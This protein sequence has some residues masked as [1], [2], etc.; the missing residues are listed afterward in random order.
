MD[1]LAEE[2]DR[3]V[4]SL[5][6][7]AHRRYFKL[8]FYQHRDFDVKGLSTQGTYNLELEHVFV[9]LTIEPKP[10]HA[11]STDPIRH[12]P[13][14]LSGRRQIWDYLLSKELQD[15]LV[16]IGAPGS[17]KTTL[18]KKIVLHIISRRR[19]RLRKTIPVLLSLRDYADKIQQNPAYSLAEAV[20]DSLSRMGGSTPP[21]GWLE[22][23]LEAGKCI[24][25]LDGLDEV[26]V[27][28]VREK[29]VDWVED[30]RKVHLDN[31]FVV[32]SRPLG[33]RNNPIS[34]FTVLEV[35]PFNRQQISRFVHNWYQTN[36]IHASGK[37]DLGVEAKAREGAED[38]LRRLHASITL[39]DLAVNPL[40]LT[41][42]AT[43]HRYRSSLPG[44]RVELY[45]EICEVFLG[46]RQQARGI[47]AD[48][49]PSQKQ[50]VLQPLAYHLMLMSRRE[51]STMEAS[52][53]IKEHLLRVA[54]IKS[55]DQEA[56]FL[57]D[58]ES[59]S[60]LLLEREAGVYGFAHLAF[61]EYLSASYARE[62]RLEEHLLDKVSDPWW[63]ETLRLYGALGDA[64]SIV[65]A[66]LSVPEPTLASIS[67][68]VDCLEESR[69]IDPAWRAKIDEFLQ[70]GVED[71]D[72]DKFRLAAQ[73]LLARRMQRFVNIAERVFIDSTLLTHAEYQL[74][75]DEKRATSRHLQP[76]HW[77]RHRF[78]PGQGMTPICGILG[79]E[80]REFCEWLCQRTLYRFS[81]PDLETSR[82]NPLAES[83]LLEPQ[84]SYWVTAGKALALHPNQGSIEV[85]WSYLTNLREADLALALAL[86]HARALSLVIASALEIAG[87]HE[88][89]SME[90]RDAAQIIARR[91]DLYE[92]GMN[93]DLEDAADRFGALDKL[94]SNLRMSDPVKLHGLKSEKVNALEIACG[95]IPEMA[96]CLR[97][98]LDVELAQHLSVVTERTRAFIASVHNR[99]LTS[100]L[101]LD[102]SRLRAIDQARSLNLKPY[103]HDLF[104]FDR[105]EGVNQHI[106]A[107]AIRPKAHRVLLWQRRAKELI[108]HRSMDGYLPFATLQA[109]I[110]GIIPVVGGIRLLRS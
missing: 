51:I 80:A 73:T 53:V 88:L 34:G 64:T 103:P 61:Q 54:G 65:K 39:M 71:E 98:G 13:E 82:E 109:C 20:R 90:A 68:A 63:H 41:M 14:K 31:R 56:K 8:L 96:N 91:L 97:W 17:G 24:I 70:R 23:K 92:T 48:L 59:S 38:L 95:L 29:V 27:P 107:N 33:Y 9:D 22:R 2:I 108:I 6:S 26:A 85:P 1:L 87:H 43:V 19:P 30:R 99:T 100:A 16:L 11:T 28:E 37:L 84:I 15:P 74:F 52:S 4:S 40:L 36:E 12:I 78:M 44:R 57:K 75:L 77:T 104:L 58:I 55:V 46:K 110:D 66:C 86:D 67:L 89:G 102:S 76:E 83:S 79:A 35:Q 47:G 81:L 45:S 49:S 18:L 32:T 69:E 93:V 72:P 105:G 50:R 60:G 106:R 10:A 62:Q 3:W 101:A 21:L 42:I 5:V 94:V 7:G 25:L